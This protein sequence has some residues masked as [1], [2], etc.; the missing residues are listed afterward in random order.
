MTAQ[1]ARDASSKNLHARSSFLSRRVTF[2]P[3]N[4]SELLRY[5][6]QRDI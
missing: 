1:T 4:P 3:N 2:A 5:D 6:I